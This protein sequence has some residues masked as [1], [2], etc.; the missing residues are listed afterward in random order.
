MKNFKKSCI[1]ISILLLS[2]SA[3]GKGIKVQFADAAKKGDLTTVNAILSNPEK[4][5]K[6]L[7]PESV[8]NNIGQSLRRAANSN[9]IEIVKA[10]MSDGELKELFL[11]YSAPKNWIKIAYEKAEKYPK[12][13]EYLKRFMVT[14]PTTTDGEPLPSGHAVT[15]DKAK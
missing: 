4:R 14:I 7:K 9:H 6:L 12:V 3:Y 11:E 13:Q 8:V 1:F 15:P 2:S 5:K 10:I